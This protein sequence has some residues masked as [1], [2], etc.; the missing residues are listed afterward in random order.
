[1]CLIIAFLD[2]ALILEYVLQ[3]IAQYKDKILAWK[4][5]AVSK[6]ELRRKV[7]SGLSQKHS[8]QSLLRPTSAPH[9]PGP[10]PRSLGAPA[11]QQRHTLSPPGTAGGG[12]APSPAASPRG[13]NRR[14]SAISR[15]PLSGG[16]I[17]GAPGEG[18]SSS[19]P[20]SPAASPGARSL[21]RRPSAISRAPAAP[22]EGVD[23][24]AAVA[25]DK[26]APLRNR[27]SS[28]IRPRTSPALA[29]EG[30]DATL[31]SIFPI[32]R[33]GSM[34]VRLKVT[35]DESPEG[36]PPASPAGKMVS[37]RSAISGSS[38]KSPRRSGSISSSPSGIPL[39]ATGPSVDAPMG[40]GLASHGS[41]RASQPQASHLKKMSSKKST[42]Q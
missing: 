40:A 41:K 39:D 18:A 35:I 7:G 5:R 4:D 8:R 21:A 20:P 17:D 26:G 42:G 16:M 10:S 1:M 22:E 29:S 25:A 19:G 38:K 6:A 30:D 15:A 24:A 33:H 9:G 28:I 27:A 34:S 36:T 31:T 11:K 3:V 37:Q 14:S 12:L 32:K 2:V 13:F 23:G